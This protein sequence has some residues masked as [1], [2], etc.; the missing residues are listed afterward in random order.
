MNEKKRTDERGWEQACL[1]AVACDMEILWG[2]SPSKLLL[3]GVFSYRADWGRFSF[4]QVLN[5][6]RLAQV[7]V[8]SL[9]GPR[10]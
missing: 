4:M 8:Y 6:P 3:P 9:A 10:D 2:N 7:F 1:S 5:R